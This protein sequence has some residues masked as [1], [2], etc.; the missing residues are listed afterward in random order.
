[1]PQCCFSVGHVRQAS[2]LS[3]LSGP[4][5][6][7]AGH[8]KIDPRGWTAEYGLHGTSQTDC[9]VQWRNYDLENSSHQESE[10]EDLAVRNRT[11]IVRPPTL[12]R[13]CLPSFLNQA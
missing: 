10:I 1:M 4:A 9:Q 2:S 3:P 5:S 6:A 12:G 11:R 13:A 8:L 7:V